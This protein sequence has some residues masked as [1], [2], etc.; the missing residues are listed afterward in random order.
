MKAIVISDIHGD[1]NALNEIIE[2]IYKLNVDKF[3]ILGDFC[4]YYGDSLDIAKRLN[5]FRLIIEAV[6]G[7]A[8]TPSFIEHSNLELPIIKNIILN[9]QIITIS[10]GHIYNEYNLPPNHG[11]IFLSGH[12]H[13]KILKFEKGII[14]A[15]P[16]SIGN[17]RDGSSGYI[18]IDDKFIK[19][20]G[21]EDNLITSLKL[22]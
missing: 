13:R 4:S 19:L 1:I 14:I 3:I 8:D 15:N 5:E 22:L 9:N 21:I 18:I 2:K 10:H 16:G 11:N 12:T 17:P 6:R 7:N 20:Y